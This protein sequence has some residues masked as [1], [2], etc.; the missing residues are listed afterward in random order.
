MDSVTIRISSHYSA[1]CV[2]LW[3]EDAHHEYTYVKETIHAIITAI[4]AQFS[5]SPH[6]KRRVDKL[7]K[8]LGADEI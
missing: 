1:H 4:Y 8:I 2:H 3:I 7:R 5:Q 6:H